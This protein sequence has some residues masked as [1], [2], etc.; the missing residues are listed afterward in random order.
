MTRLWN[1]WRRLPWS[2]SRHQV[3]YVFKWREGQIWR[4]MVISQVGGTG[5][6]TYVLYVVMQLACRRVAYKAFLYQLL[7]MAMLHVL[8]LFATL[9]KSNS[10]NLKIIALKKENSP[11]TPGFCGSMLVFVFFCHFSAHD[12]EIIE[13]WW[14]SVYSHQPQIMGEKGLM[15]STNVELWIPYPS[16]G[17]PTKIDEQVVGHS[18]SKVFRMLSVYQ[19]YLWWMKFLHHT[20]RCSRDWGGSIDMFKIF[21][22]VRW[23]FCLQKKEYWQNKSIRVNL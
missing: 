1:L 22:G 17:R 21:S 20:L 14:S 5:K 9:P 19:Y 12:T 23:E 8:S 11:S 16:M 6:K 18:G 4:E 3:E 10:S 2:F 13:D 7:A 15:W